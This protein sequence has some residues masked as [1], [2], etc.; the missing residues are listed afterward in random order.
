M[1]PILMSLPPNRVRRNYRGGLLLDRMEN[2]PHPADSDRPEDWIASTVRASNPGMP[3]I[4][5]E[6][7]ATVPTPP[8]G[9]ATVQEIFALAPGHFL[10]PRHVERIGTVLG[11]L[12]KLLDSAMRLHVQAHP[13]AEFARRHL[14]SRWGKLETYLV[15][16]ERTPG[17]GYL[18]L[19]FQHEVT[20]VEWRR[21]VY[22]QDVAAMDAL[23]EKVPVSPGEVW[24]VPGGLPHAIGEGLLVLEVMEPTDLVV[25]CEFEREGIVVPPAAR[26]MGCEPDFALTVFDHSVVP[27]GE[28]TGRCRVRPRI[29][30]GGQGFSEELLIGAEQTDCFRIHRV[31]AVRGYTRPAAG[32]V[33]IGI[34]LSGQGAIASGGETLQAKRGDRFLVAAAAPSLEIRPEES[35]FVLAFCRPADTG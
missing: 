8:G 7:L 35:P 9:M 10:G 12:V 25:R 22:E 13:T 26:F 19:G 3:E 30:D 34:A 32:C 31:T 21:I 33:E 20:P 29:L 1:P 28:V 6:G 4:L 23:F 18:R 2:A 16:A 17:A 27:V 24:V 15:L 14:G 5:D 11:F